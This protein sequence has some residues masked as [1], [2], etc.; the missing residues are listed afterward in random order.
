M[1]QDSLETFVRLASRAF[2]AVGCRIEVAAENGIAVVRDLVVEFGPSI[3]CYRAATPE[4]PFMTFPADAPDAAA[5]A[6]AVEVL[7][8]IVARAVETNPLSLEAGAPQGQD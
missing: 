4:E 2:E 6:V 3:S 7:K 1:P 8:G 5:A